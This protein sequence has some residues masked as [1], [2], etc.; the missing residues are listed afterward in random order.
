MTL[1]MERVLTG[2][3]KTLSHYL[4]PQTQ[5]MG[6]L[7]QQLCQAFI[8]AMD[9]Y[10]LF[11]DGSYCLSDYRLRKLGLT[12]TRS[13]N[14]WRRLRNSTVSFSLHRFQSQVSVYLELSHPTI[15][16]SLGLSQPCF[17]ALGEQQESVQVTGH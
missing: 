10:F 11:D 15:T 2:Q 9:L 3:L 16:L 13:Q 17:L 7:H 4:L 12:L 1:T 14:M 5:K 6:S 8:S